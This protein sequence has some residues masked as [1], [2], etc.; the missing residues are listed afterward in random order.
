MT[1]KQPEALRLA[2]V[3]ERLNSGVH[4]Q[5]ILE[6]YSA[7]A[8]EL[9]RQ[10][11]RIVELEKENSY[12]NNA[13]AELEAHLAEEQKSMDEKDAAR[14]RMVELISRE[15]M[16]HPDKRTALEEVAAY[17]HATH[18]GLDMQGAVDAAI[19]AQT[20]Q[21]GANKWLTTNLD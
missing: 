2:D 15:I 20:K 6:E 18:S 4:S 14:W 13:C 12:L 16:M 19:A 21:D 3:V 17:M 7:A 11:A 5:A 9:R 8:S 1:N 10:H